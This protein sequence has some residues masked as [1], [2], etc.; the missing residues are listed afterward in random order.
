V[1]DENF[2]LGDEAEVPDEEGHWASFMPSRSAG[3]VDAPALQTRIVLTA[4]CGPNRS[5]LR[6]LTIADYP[7]QDCQI[8]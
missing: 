5:C 4:A 1:E 6:I 7:A 2:S 8:C 3:F